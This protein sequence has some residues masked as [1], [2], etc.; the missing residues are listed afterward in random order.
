M[1]F[2]DKLR[3]LRESAGITQYQ[4]AKRA[5]LTKQALSRLELGERQPFWATVQALAKALGVS[6]D[7]FAESEEPS[8]SELP[9][10]P[11]VNP[12][13]TAVE[14]EEKSPPRRRKRS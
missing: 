10:S 2:A 5:G 9:D 6:C 11:V 4:L 1:A 7:A 14:G 8:V 12:A 3:A 13:P